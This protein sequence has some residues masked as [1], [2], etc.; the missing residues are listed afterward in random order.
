MQLIGKCGKNSI[1]IAV[2]FRRHNH[3]PGQ[4]VA[5]AP[6]SVA[7]EVCPMPF[8]YVPGEFSVT[9]VLFADVATRG[10]AAI[11]ALPL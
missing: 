2:D 9:E 7:N 6:L 11:R 1:A 4:G 5:H 10:V 8:E 3:P